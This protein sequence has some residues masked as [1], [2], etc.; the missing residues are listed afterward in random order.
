MKTGIVIGV[1]LGGTYVR[2]G[3]FDSQGCL[4]AA[5]EMPIRAAQGPQAG[6]QRIQDLIEMVWKISEK[7]PLL[8]IGIGSTGP[9]DPQRGI[10]NNP[11][12]LPGWENVSIAAWLEQAFHVPITL[13]NDADVAALG[14]YWRGVG[15]SVPRLYAVTVGTGIGTALI[16]DGQIYRGMDGL[17]PEGGHIILDPAGPACYCGANGCWES[18]C[19][20]PAIARQARQADLRGSL[21]LE[22][23]GG[24]LDEIDARLVAEAA[25]AGDAVALAIVDRVAHYFALGI[26]NVILSI[27]P[28]M[29]VLGGGVMKSADL[30]L[31]R[32]RQTLASHSVI[33]PAERVRIEVAQLGNYA[34]LYGAA[35]TIWSTLNPRKV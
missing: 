3:A 5:R 7:R 30:F 16:L 24:N 10:I 15:Q 25:R 6:L 21:L 8:G 29:I 11:F 23:S 32:L 35:Y 2:A 14:E 33:L 27:T 1:D 28:E 22:M 17:H 12:T 20:G 19:S 4:L 26:V 13:E 31:P 18:L 9:V 34:G